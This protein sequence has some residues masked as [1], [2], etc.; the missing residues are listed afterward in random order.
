M[1]RFVDWEIE[2][3]PDETASAHASRAGSG[4]DECG[5]LYCRNF[6]RA[7]GSAFPDV[8]LAFL[9]QLGVGPAMET[10][11]YH[12]HEIQPNLHNY[13]GWFH[14]IAKIHSGGSDYQELTPE[15]SVRVSVRRHVLPE[16]FEGYEVIQID[17]LTQVPWLLD[18][19][20][21]L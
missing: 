2:P 9:A 7:R 10:E 19:P 4:T 20:F 3:S 17:F 15:F 8:F 1:T 13:G 16:A 11:V 21:D 12:T 5:C 6:S 14:A 18:E